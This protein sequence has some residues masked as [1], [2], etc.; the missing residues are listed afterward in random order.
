MFWTLL[1]T[2]WARFWTPF[3]LPF[4]DEVYSEIS[5]MGFNGIKSSVG[6]SVKIEN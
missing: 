2:I 6:D 4:I 1:D 5:E 3:G